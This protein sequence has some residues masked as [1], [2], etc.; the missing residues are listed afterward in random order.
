MRL[1]QN[2][3]GDNGALGDVEGIRT[4]KKEGAV[5]V[6]SDPLQ[7][8]VFGPCALMRELFGPITTR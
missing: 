3:A 1:P 8:V 6:R 2:G 7:R 4:G 5:L